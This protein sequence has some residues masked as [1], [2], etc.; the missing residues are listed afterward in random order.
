MAGFIFDPARVTTAA[1]H[2]LNALEFT[3]GKGYR[4]VKAAEA[5]TAGDFVFLTATG[6]ARPLDST[7]DTTQLGLG[8]G[9]ANTALA[10]NEY[11]WI[12]VYGATT[13][14]FVAATVT[15]GAQLYGHATEGRVSSTAT[16]A[17]IGGLY[18]AARTG[19]GLVSGFLTFPTIQHYA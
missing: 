8:G 9:I 19:A 11:G 4:Y 17:Q 2:T 5:I 7:D 1:S 10:A 12:Q 16:D 3:G 18:A 6:G 14:V 15:A 13:N